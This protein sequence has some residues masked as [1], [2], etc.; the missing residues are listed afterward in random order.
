MPLRASEP[1][2]TVRTRWAPAGAALA[3]L[4]WLGACGGAANESTAVATMTPVGAAAQPTT[5]RVTTDPVSAD[6][7]T[8]SRAS[9]SESQAAPLTVPITATSNATDRGYVTV[10]VSI[11]GGAPATLWLDTGSSGLLVDASAVGSAVTATDTPITIDY[12]SGNLVGSIAEATV[13]I[14]GVSTAQPIAFGLLDAQKSTFQTPPGTVGIIGIGTDDDSDVG[15]QGIYAPQLQLPAPYNSGMTL[16]VAANG[17]GSWTLGPVAAD[18][19]AITTP[20]TANPGPAAGVPSGYPAFLR[21]V[22]LCWTIGTAAASCG[23]TDLDTGSPASLLS[24][25]DYT[26]LAASGKLL[27]SGTPVEVALPGGGQLWSFTTGSTFADDAV[28]V[29]DIGGSRFNTGLGFFLD[30]TVAW[31]YTGGRLVVGPAA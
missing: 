7:A 18:G 30:R 19:G 22:D 24:A 25:T 2:R 26:D 29:D 21:Q 11:G 20:L 31:D 6:Q 23:P 17:P 5:N 16:Q 14:G 28:G 4:L 13:E 12:T 3:G 27:P 15:A 9:A 8:T 1:T 10:Q